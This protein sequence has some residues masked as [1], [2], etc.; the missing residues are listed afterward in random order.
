MRIQRPPWS[1]PSLRFREQGRIKLSRA[2]RIQLCTRE[3][4]GSSEHERAEGLT[5]RWSWGEGLWFESQQ[6]T[7]LTINTRL[8]P[9]KANLVA[10]AHPTILTSTNAVQLGAAQKASVAAK[11][12]TGRCCTLHAAGQRTSAVT[13]PDSPSYPPGRAERTTALADPLT[14]AANRHSRCDSPLLAWPDMCNACECEAKT[15]PVSKPLSEF[16]WEG[17]WTHIMHRLRSLTRAHIKYRARL[18]ICLWRDGSSHLAP[19]ESGRLAVNQQT[20]CF[21]QPRVGSS[22][23][24]NDHWRL[25]LCKAIPLDSSRGEATPPGTKKKH[26]MSGCRPEGRMPQ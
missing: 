15:A 5:Q 25:V 6:E 11:E 7:D 22:T 17:K 10:R 23:A 2:N 3:H 21:E 20:L 1:N 26:R 12:D 4:S 24:R 8:V 19:Q 9:S 13:I 16:V 18:S 14:S